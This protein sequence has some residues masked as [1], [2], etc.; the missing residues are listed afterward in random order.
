M[1]TPCPCLPY[2]VDVCYRVR[3]L[4]C[5]Q[6]EWITEW[7]N[8]WS[9]YSASLGVVRIKNIVHLDVY[10][11]E[12]AIYARKI[13]CYLTLQFCGSNIRTKW[14]LIL[15]DAYWLQDNTTNS[16]NLIFKACYVLKLTSNLRERSRLVDRRCFWPR[17]CCTFQIQSPLCTP[18]NT[19]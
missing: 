14:K 10:R 11:A 16:S 5:S 3:E 7:Q 13:L 19:S 15:A 17:T 9:Q 1:V 12:H 4:S 6:T 18:S 8:E 2:L